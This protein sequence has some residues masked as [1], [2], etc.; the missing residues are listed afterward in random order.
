MS[1]ETENRDGDQNQDEEEDSPALE[2][3][4]RLP[5]RRVASLYDVAVQYAAMDWYHTVTSGDLDFDL[6]PKYLS[7]LTPMEKSDLYGEDDN[8]LA[9]NVD[10][11]DPDNPKLDNENPVE[12]R[13]I[14]E[15]SRFKLGHSYPAN[16][17]SSMTD[18]SITT[19]KSA[20]P[21]HLSGRRD[22]AWGTNNIQ[23]RFTGWAQ[24]E[25]AEEVIE[26][27]SVE[28]AW[29]VEA[30]SK[31]GEDEEKMSRLVDEFP[32]DTDEEDEEHEV[33]VTVRVKLPD[34]DEY[35]YP[36]EIPALN[37]VMV[38]QKAERLENTSVED[39]KGEGVGYVTGEEKDVTGGS[40][41]LLSMY[42]KKQREHFP[43]V[44]AD[45]ASAWRSRPITH[46]TA[47]DIATATSLFDEFYRALGEGRRLYILPYLS[48]H[49]ENTTPETVDWFVENVFNEL[50]EADEEEFEERVEDLYRDIDVATQSSETGDEWGSSA[51]AY[52]D[53][54]FATVFY[55]SGNPNRIYFES[56]SP[57]ATYRPGELEDAHLSV[58]NEDEF[59]REGIFSNIVEESSSSLLNREGTLRRLALFGTYFDQTTEPTLNSEEASGQPKAGDI[60]DIRARRL[61]SF[62]TGETISYDELFEEY[63]NRIVQIQRSSFGDDSRRNIPLWAV[64]EQ[65]T[66]LR[67]LERSGVMEDN[68]P[69]KLEV[70]NVSQQETEDIVPQDREYESRAE[71]LDDFI[72]NHPVLDD[73]RKQ[74]VFLL[75]GLVG[76]ISAYQRKN[77]VSSTLVRR[78]PI[79]YLTKQSIKEVTNEVIQMNNT[80]IEA[81]EQTSSGMNARYTN[82]LPDLMLSEDPSSWNFSQNELQWLYALGITYGNQD[83]SLQDN[84]NDNNEEEE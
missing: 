2:V 55:V 40:T 81:D 34:S 29:V 20:S 9:A 33:F 32:L 43:D 41:G 57:E 6:D 60:D 10:L 38:K 24:S 13:T 82:P 44:P 46:E 5:S 48:S 49:P 52:E 19:H 25:A 31:L 67:A 3:L 76:R 59:G 16:K 74:A 53:V 21:Y 39:A 50:R 15:S 75:G 63:L 70:E 72:A 58:L 73:N 65:Y 84:D 35:K 28:D 8:V 80:Y 78:Y 22:D 54:R 83:T 30:L 69:K 12:L 17:T 77:N 56:M 1:V 61:R 62:L 64:I 45:G 11:S 27:D 51:E 14:D 37:E 4:G 26:E 42:G 23:D 7:F 71:R 47:A 36:G 18:Y 79:D 68:R 66:Q